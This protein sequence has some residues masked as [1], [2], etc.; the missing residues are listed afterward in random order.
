MLEYDKF[1]TFRELSDGA[2]INP[3]LGGQ[4]KKG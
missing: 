1:V 2:S 4:Q 3:D